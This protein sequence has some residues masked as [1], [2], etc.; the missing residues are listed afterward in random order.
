MMKTVLC[1]IA[2]A[3]LSATAVLGH[4]VAWPA[5]APRIKGVGHCAKGACQRR[6]AFEPTLPHR[7]VGSGKCAGQGA[8]GYR[9]GGRF[10]CSDK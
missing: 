5:S 9:F 2:M 3:T 10:T 8:G 7:H 4:E 6:A 1:A